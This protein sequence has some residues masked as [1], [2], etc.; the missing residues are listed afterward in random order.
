MNKKS[1]KN[2]L[3]F[4]AL[5]FA[6]SSCGS[7]AISYQDFSRIQNQEIDVQSVIAKNNF[8][9]A[10]NAVFHGSVVK[11]LPNDTSGLKHEKFM[12]QI[13][14]GLDGKYNGKIVVVAHDISMAPF[15]PIQIGS[16]LEI[17][18]DFISNANPMVLHWT[19]KDDKHVHPDGYIILDGKIYQ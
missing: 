4:F 12:F 18:G 11:I 8:S 16:K 1:F 6:L 9:P 17:K 15:V 7:G 3:P 13:S 19:H 5:T 14:D 2:L 10:I